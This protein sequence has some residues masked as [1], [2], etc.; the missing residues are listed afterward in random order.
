MSYA[1]ETEVPI[2][3][4]RREIELMLE[5]AGA[6]A[7]A[8]MSRPS[9]SVIAFQFREMTVRFHLPLPPL[10]AFELSPAKKLRAQTEQLRAQA[11]DHRA[12][13]R[14]LGLGIKAKLVF[15]ESGIRTFEQEFLADF[16][17]PNGKTLGESAI[18]Q[19]AE[20]ATHGRMPTLSLNA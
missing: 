17:M 1:A 5:K 10:K 12:R 2:E 9:E 4:T 8:F 13:W 19:L 11:K 6:T 16:V 3:R 14:A 18:P 15:V 20:A 7:F